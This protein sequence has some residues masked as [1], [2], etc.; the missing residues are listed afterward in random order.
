MDEIEGMENEMDNE[1][2]FRV[3]DVVCDAQKGTGK[4]ANVSNRLIHAI[5]DDNGSCVYRID[6]KRL[7]DDGKRLS[8]YH[9]TW[10]QVFGNLPDIKPKRKVKRWVNLYHALSHDGFEARLSY[11]SAAYASSHAD[12]GAVAVAVEIEVDE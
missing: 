7:D 6:G 2:D 12:P 5:F 4:V 3:G 11:T 1:L 9:G 10:E 8:L